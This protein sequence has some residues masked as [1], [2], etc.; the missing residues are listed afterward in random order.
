M[1][2]RHKGKIVAG[3]VLLAAAGT[4]GAAIY[5][6]KH[7]A[8]EVSVAKVKVQDVVGPPTARSR[9]KGRST[10]RPWSWARS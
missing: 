9:R 2:K 1:W 8:T 7:R 4:V 6:K 10:S 3:V 5:K